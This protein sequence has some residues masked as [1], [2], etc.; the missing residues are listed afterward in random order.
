MNG[1]MQVPW[2]RNCRGVLLPQ[3]INKNSGQTAF[4]KR[5]KN[6][7]VCARSEICW[8]VQLLFLA[9]HTLHT[10][11]RTT[12]VFYTLWA[13]KFYSCCAKTQNPTVINSWLFFKRYVFLTV[14][15]APCGFFQFFVPTLNFKKSIILYALNHW[16]SLL[17][18]SKAS[19]GT[20]AVFLSLKSNL[21]NKLNTK[22]WIYL[23]T[24]SRST[25]GAGRESQKMQ[26][27]ISWF[28]FSGSVHNN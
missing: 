22:R 4:D 20:Q 13:L 5:P 26:I 1:K 18:S 27:C 10:M 21:M 3:R 25:G 9:F 14:R 8:R 6:T 16:V 11:T 15:G 19:L 23:A 24:L 17:L 7:V 2:Y 12:D 28:I